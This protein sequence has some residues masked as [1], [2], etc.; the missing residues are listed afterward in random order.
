MK[1]VISLQN[2][3]NGRIIAFSAE[4]ED[5]GVTCGEFLRRR[6]VSR[7]LVTKLKR[8]YMGI[9]RNGEV[10]RTVDRMKCGDRVELRLEDKKLLEPNS[11][12]K[13]PVVYEDEDAVVFNKPVGM[14]VHPSIKH[15]G[16]TLGNCFAAMY[17]Q[18]TFRPVNRLDRDTSG[19]CA[20]AKTTY[21]ANRL[22]GSIS[23]VYTAAVQGVPVPH[24]IGNPLIRWTE[25]AEGVYRIDAPIGR[26]GESI[27]R[28]EVRADGKSAVTSYTIIKEN[29]RHSLLSIS[30][31][32]GRTHQIRVHFSAL[33][34]PLAG[35]DFYGGSL[36]YCTAQALHCSEMS[37]ARPSDGEVVNIS[38]GIR[39]DMENLFE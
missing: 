17:P 32:T 36:E 39:E 23:K 22:V 25:T 4:A 18:L 1:K 30:L 28:R 3:Y 33:G 24:E 27:I 8:T 20:V 7:R 10:L 5:E 15:Q 13:V 11:A 9:T 37:F 34:Y 19:L 2:W 35:D 14:P 21:A 26:A 6:G 12:L 16:D 38:C 29:G 31:E